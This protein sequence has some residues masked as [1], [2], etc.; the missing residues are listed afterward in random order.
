MRLLCIQRHVLCYNCA[1]T[2][3]TL[4]DHYTE[5]QTDTQPWSYSSR[6]DFPPKVAVRILRWISWKERIRTWQTGLSCNARKC[7]CLASNHNNYLYFSILYPLF[8]P[9][10]LNGI[11]GEIRKTT[12]AFHVISNFLSKHWKILW[13][14]LRHVFG[15]RAFVM[16]ATSRVH[17]TGAPIA[18]PWL[19]QPGHSSRYSCWRE[20][21]DSTRGDRRE[22]REDCHD[23]QV[24]SVMEM[25]ET[26]DIPLG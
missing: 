12:M 18:G 21:E 13:P 23:L 17:A 24:Y 4:G 8:S 26:E 20:K 14:S 10:T 2:W 1:S 25:R 3:R 7:G 19:L 6:D 11:L 16:H 5:L 22:I 15:F 9:H